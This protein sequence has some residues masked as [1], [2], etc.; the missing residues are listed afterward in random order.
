MDLLRE[1]RSQLRDERRRSEGRLA[2]EM[3]TLKA[4]MIAEAEAAAR[5]GELALAR[6]EFEA[7]AELFAEAAGNLPTRETALE[8]EYRQRQAE[9]LAAKAEMTGDA[10]TL[11]AA[12]GAFRAAAKLIDKAA[13]PQVWARV[14][15]G[16]GDMLM[17]LGSRSDAG[18]TGSH[19]ELEQ[20]ALAYEAAIAVI[21]RAAHPM[22][23]ALVQ[24]SRAVALIEIG[25]RVD[26]DRHWLAAA[27]ALMPALE[28]FEA[29]GAADLAEAARAKLRMVAGALQPV[30]AA[31]ALPARSA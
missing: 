13:E 16:L 1:V 25:N 21:D 18:A 24:L 4:S 30:P 31:R 3:E 14:Q 15:V 17:A 26:R 22:R 20:A 2:E 10:R 8:L 11:V 27:T 6:C 12:A 29:R 7:A 28:V 19:V 23:W 5:L 9:A